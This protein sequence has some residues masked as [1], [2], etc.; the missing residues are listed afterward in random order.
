AGGW[1]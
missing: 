1:R